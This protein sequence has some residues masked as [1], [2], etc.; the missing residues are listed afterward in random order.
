MYVEGKI[1]YRQYTNQNG[2]LC[3]VTEILV[4]RM[5]QLASARPPQQSSYGQPYS[6]ATEPAPTGYVPQNNPNMREEGDDLPF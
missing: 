5:M 6:P 1:R 4:D 3:N 2:V